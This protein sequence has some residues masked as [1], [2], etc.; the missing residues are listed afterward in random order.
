MKHAPKKQG[1]ILI[2]MALMTTTLIIFFGMVVSVGHL[3]QAR[4]NLQ[5]AVDLAAMSGASWQ[6]RFMNHISV[7]NYRLRQNY[8]WTLYDLYVTQSRFNQGFKDEVLGG[9]GLR[10]QIPETGPLIFGICQQLPGWNPT[11]PD[12]LVFSSRGSQDTDLCKLVKT[13]NFQIPLVTYTPVPS[14]NPAIIAINFAIYTTR[15]EQLSI[16]EESSGHNFG[17]FKY[18][19]KSLRER[20]NLQM[21]EFAYILDR[22]R[23]AFSQA[24]APAPI[25]ANAPHEGD[26]TMWN[27][28]YANLI[29]ANQ[30]GAQLEYLNAPEN[31]T[32]IDNN[33]GSL[34]T[35][36]GLQGAVGGNFEQYFERQRATIKIKW[37]NF[38]DC[39]V[40]VQEALWAGDG[41]SITGGGAAEFFFLGLSRTRG[42]TALPASENAPSIK[43]PFNIILR[44][45]VR[46][47][48]LFW[49]RGL[50][51]TLVAVSGA[52]P[53]GSRVAPSIR[54]SNLEVAGNI[55]MPAGGTLA[56]MSFYP[57]DLPGGGN[58]LYGMGHK[59]I[60]RALFQNLPAPLSGVNNVR[61]HVGNSSADCSGGSK[62]LCMAL[63]P[64]LY[65]SLLWT[66]FP[67]PQQV[68]G[69]NSADVEAFPG[70]V[71]LALN[72]PGEPPAPGGGQVGRLGPQLMAKAYEM[73]DRGSFSS[74]ATLNTWHTTALIGADSNFRQGSKPLFF[75][76]GVSTASA[77]SPDLELSE[78]GT[79]GT[80]GRMGYQ[81]KLTS[82]LSLCNEIRIAQNDG[83]ISN[84]PPVLK[85]YCPDSGPGV[86]Y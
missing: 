42:S 78:I 74:P 3:V 50:T 11:T 83:S 10:D 61:P 55:A 46:P 24:P 2:M 19:M 67:F 33:I 36:I 73:V 40:F 14:I 69:R 12:E 52:K 32:Y 66:V 5:N 62:F 80:K 26:R 44:A 20:N 49:P 6:A 13:P 17:Y 31:R 72:R 18:L 68:H 65:E 56:N 57:G 15:Q 4:I 63:A 70:E 45:S 47:D 85:L 54:S 34:A 58:G 59:R 30:T 37:V 41:T 29:T 22:F 38:K 25:E 7:I 60:L 28:F 8:K 75:G 64:T 86:P 1:Q 76:D 16:C 48:L 77:F 71:N 51:P 9:S 21:E 43:V 82:L 81:I 27:T 35:A 39:K 79:N 84:I 23:I 53:F